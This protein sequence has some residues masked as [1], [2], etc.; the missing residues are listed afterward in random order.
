[1]R[2]PI[3]IAHRGASG[4]RPEHTLASYRLAIALGADYVEPDLVSTRD[5]VLVARHEAEI[6]RTT[7]VARRAEFAGRLTTKEVDGRAATGWFVDDFTLAEL[8]T[9]RVVERLPALRPRNARW[10]G[11][12]DVPTFEEILGLVAAESERLGRPIG[13][14]PETKHPAYF[15]ELGLGL[16]EPLLEA[17]ARHGSGG[18]DAPVFVQSFDPVSLQWLRSRTGLPL[19]QLVGAT[20]LPHDQRDLVTS[21]GLRRVAAWADAVGV[22]KDLVLPRHPTTGTL[23]DPTDLVADA[24]AAGLLVHVWTMRDEHDS[25][26]ETQAFLDAGVDGLFTDQP[27]TTLEARRR[28]ASGI[29]IHAA[30]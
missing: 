3:V 15:A 13:V 2:E 11:R 16:E 20:G 7:D 26:E 27:D 25:V 28:Y 12:Y 6:G 18:P 10:D 9:L 1:M 17:L 5:G 23:G 24:H 22:E 29:R 8:K 4:Y 30:M 21:T 19:V 14:Y